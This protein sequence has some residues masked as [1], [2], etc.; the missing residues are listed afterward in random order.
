MVGNGIS[1][2]FKM[3]SAQ[4]SGNVLA[5]SAAENTKRGCRPHKTNL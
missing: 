5:Q 4:D 1:Q 3:S 2:S